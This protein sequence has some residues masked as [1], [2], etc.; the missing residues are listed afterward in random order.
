MATKEP[1]SATL[2]GEKMSQAEIKE[3]Q[4]QNPD[5]RVM[6]IAEKGTMG[7]GS[8]RMSGVN[9]VA[10]LTGK[11]ASPYVPFVNNAPIVAGTNGVSPIFMTTVDVTGGIGLNLKNWEKTYDKKGNLIINEGGDPVRRKMLEHS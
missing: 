4:K 9:N 7:V 10:L 5:K 6:L 2:K 1:M 8:S 11:Q 3:L